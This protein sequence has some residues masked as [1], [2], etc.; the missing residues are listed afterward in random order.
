M[1]TKALL[2]GL[3]GFFLGGLVVAVAA[4]AMPGRQAPD[5]T[6]TV[7]ESYSSSSTHMQTNISGK[8]GD[9]YDRAFIQAM[10]DHHQGAIDMARSAGSN[11]KHQELKDLAGQIISSQQAEIEQMRAWQQQWGYA[12]DEAGGH[13]MPMMR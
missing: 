5:G 10:I 11:A 7:N 1:N 2:S 3:I 9:D 6:T 13:S 4:S 8:T 12:T